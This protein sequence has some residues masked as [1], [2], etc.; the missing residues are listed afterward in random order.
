M[1]DSLNE[2]FNGMIEADT[3]GAV[4]GLLKSTLDMQPAHANGNGAIAA[5][6]PIE[7][8]APPVDFVHALEDLSMPGLITML[9]FSSNIKDP[10]ISSLRGTPELIT[11]IIET[12]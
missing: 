5:F 10:G 8:T 1:P 12:S 2:L 7:E 4:V 3:L 6:P 9:P 11:L